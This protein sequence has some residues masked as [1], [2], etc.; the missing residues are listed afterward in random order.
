[1]QPA[2]AEFSIFSTCIQ[3]IQHK[4]ENLNLLQK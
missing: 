2:S 3:F 4:F 1:M